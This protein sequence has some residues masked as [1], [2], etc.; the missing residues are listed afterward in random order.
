[1][2]W[3]WV[4]I[5]NAFSRVESLDDMPYRV[6]EMLILFNLSF[7]LY[8]IIII[9]TNYK[10]FTGNCASNVLIMDTFESNDL[11]VPNVLNVDPKI[12]RFISLY[13]LKAIGV[14]VGSVCWTVIKIHVVCTFIPNVFAIVLVWVQLFSLFEDCYYVG[15]YTVKLKIPVQYIDII[16][17]MLFICVNVF[18]CFIIFR[19]VTVT[20][21]FLFCTHA[22]DVCTIAVSIK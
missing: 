5:L 22:Y 13:M 12:V 16:Y 6:K 4:L 1:M 10:I 3:S 19:S 11:S 15:Y 9:M 2:A 21:N 7:A 18:I 14:N 17:K 20:G 8:D